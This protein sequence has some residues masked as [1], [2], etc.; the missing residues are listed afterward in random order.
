MALFWTEEKLDILKSYLQLGLS[1]VKIAQKMNS[2]YGAVD[3]AIKRYG[4]RSFRKEA[5]S[6][7]KFVDNIDLEELQD[8]NFEEAKQD[9]K[10][11]WTISKSTK[12]SVKKPYKI[13]LVTSDYH[14]PHQNDNCIK[15]ILKLMDDIKFDI[16]IVNGD[17]LDYGCISH[18]NAHKH[19]TLEMTRL[20][21]DYIIGNSILD[22]MDKRLPK[23]CQKYFL[24]GNHEN[25]VYDLLEK[26]PQLEGMVEPKEL[27]FL[28]KRGY[29]ISKY[30]DLVQFGKLY[31]THGIYATANSVK[32]H[33]DELKVNVLFAHT[34]TIGM[35]LS[36]S[37]ARD[38]AFAG[39]NA[40]CI[41]D[42][43]PDYMRGRPH[44]WAHG[45]AVVY[46]FQ[47]GSFDVKL[48]RV[49]NGKFIFNNKIYDG[50]K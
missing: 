3:G 8:V 43:S 20:K 44:G 23:H 6:A 31:V 47:D 22:E 25:W 50:S 1:I 28:K 21:N 17:F 37:P 29:D 38:V 27:L 39:Y 34:H 49:I 9:A 11:K 5:P 46:F 45:F 14:I 18:W 30:N 15:G 26:I 12:K 32:K 36:S 48:I 2:S 41:C 42:M 33:L 16:N 13:G 19:K 24:E 7:T 35:R 4:L 10:L 40:G